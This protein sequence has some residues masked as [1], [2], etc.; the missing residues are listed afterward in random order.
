F[1][2]NIG[3]SFSSLV[4]SLNT[5]NEPPTSRHRP[6]TSYAPL[7]NAH[8][9]VLPSRAR[10]QGLCESRGQLPRC[11][12]VGLVRFRAVPGKNNP[13]SSNDNGSQSFLTFAAFLAA[14]STN[15]FNSG[16]SLPSYPVARIQVSMSCNFG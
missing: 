8:T 16:L 9:F 5:T 2:R 11:L 4:C 7:S 14:A 10:T 1:F 15:V 6:L 13:F 3:F 12:A